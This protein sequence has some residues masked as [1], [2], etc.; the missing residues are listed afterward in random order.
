MPSISEAF[1]QYV[2][3]PFLMFS[4]LLLNLPFEGIQNTG[5]RLPLLLHACE[6]GLERGE[7]P[8]AIMN[9]FFRETLQLEDESQQ[10]DFMFKVVQYVE[11]QVVLFDSVE[12]AAAKKIGSRDG[13]PLLR[14]IRNDESGQYV[15]ALRQFRGRIVFTAHPTQFYPPQVLGIINRLRRFIERGDRRRMTATLQQLGMTSL[16]SSRKPTPLDEAHNIIHLMREHHYD[17]AAQL[18]GEIKAATGDASFD[19][20]RLIE[21]GFWPGGDRDGN[22]F[23]TAEITRKVAE[24]LRLAI[25]KCYNRDVKRLEAKLTFKGVLD[26]VSALRATIYA[27][28]FDSEARLD[29]MDLLDRLQHIRDDV[30]QHYEGLYVDEIDLFMDKVRLFG[31]HF[32]SM[33]I[34]QHHRIHKEA[35]T[36]VLK[37]NGL[38]SERLDELSDSDL[39]RILL[40]EPL[41]LDTLDLD[42]L[43]PVV[44]DTFTTLRLIPQ[45]QERNGER[46]CNRYIISNADDAWSIL[47]VFG[48]ARWCQGS[49]DPVLDIIPLF[50]TVKGMDAAAD[51]MRSLFA[52]P[53]YR[54]HVSRRSGRQTIML[55]FSDGTKDGGYLKANWAI[56]QTKEALTAVCREADVKVVFFDG[57]GGPPARGG[58]STNRFYASQGP[59]I[60]RHALELTIQGQVITS[61]YGTP[62]LF[63]RNLEELIQAGI[64]GGAPG[65]ITP[66]MS[67]VDIPEPDRQL[68][69]ELSDEAYKAYK[70]LKQH[71]Q[72]VPYLERMSTL[73]FYSKVNIGS[74]PVSRGSTEKLVFEDLRAIPFVGSWS[75]LKQNVPGYFGLGTA[76]GKLEQAGRLD[77]AARLFHDVPF[78]KTLVL[79]SMMS[80]S[81]CN[82]QLTAYME[83]DPEFGSFWREIRDEYRRTISLLLKIS[84]YDVLMEEEEKSR[85]SVSIRERI[86]L[87]LLVIQQYAL[88]RLGTNPSNK[89]VLEKLVIRTLYGNINASRNAV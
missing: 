22:P 31:A 41:S 84:G 76:L 33:D 6:D 68:L 83:E 30:R 24:E 49:D 42:A 34:R 29:P 62:H 26:R 56:H 23:V 37:A 75:Q 47:F 82:F 85:Q 3:E 55:G 67:E 38:I 32:A 16:L 18:Y 53:V 72:F 36:A 46:G 5:E 19:N 15:E 79:N 27:A 64:G 39:K 10:I 80:L 17:A 35:V 66:E 48:L 74:R 78:F 12:E 52:Q 4:T 21:L 40:E 89:E 11:R 9:R 60:A 65:T 14:L 54:A 44:A 81:K 87:P 58:G 43:D 7:E 69:E 25:I 57:R 86:V 61:M 13:S 73:R 63:S 70:A 45:I 71:P 28:L 59:A 50:E 8:S 51:V 20:D 2:H 88:Q 77:E 1:R